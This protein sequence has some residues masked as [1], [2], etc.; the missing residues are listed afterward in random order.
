M[1]RKKL[2][3]TV[4]DE[5]RDKGKTFV[6]TEMAAYKAESWAM[7]ALI[8]L[9]GNNA[10]MP[11]GFEL[12]GMAGLAQLG[13]RALGGL[14][15]EVAEPLMAEMMDC[16]EV[17]PDPNKPFVLRPLIEDDIEEVATRIKLRLEVFKLHVDFFKSAAE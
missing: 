13:I 11:E 17:M 9:I 12:S 4:A 2:N 6:I 15:W 1:A 10:E 5:G 3:Y 7:R 14:K 8:A 16:V